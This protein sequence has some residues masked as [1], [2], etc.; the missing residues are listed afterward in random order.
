MTMIPFWI[1][2]SEFEM[3]HC[4]LF[5][6]FTLHCEGDDCER[7]LLNVFSC[8][9]LVTGPARQIV[10]LW[11]AA[12]P[13]AVLDAYN[14]EARNYDPVAEAAA[15]RADDIHDARLNERNAA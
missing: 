8:H 14:E 3:G 5:G 13:S 9:Q 1:E 10:D 7:R 6:D 15:S 2:K 11:F 12:N 4:V